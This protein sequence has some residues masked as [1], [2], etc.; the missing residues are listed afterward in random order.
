MCEDIARRVR[1][2]TRRVLRLASVRAALVLSLL[3]PLTASE[4][5]AAITFV[6]NIGANAS[7]TTGTSIAVM[8]PSAIPVGNEVVLTVAF[9]ATSGTVSVSDT[10]HGTYAVAA[11]VTNASNVRTVILAVRVTSAYS[12]GQTITVATPTA[13]RR[14]LSAN[15]FSG[16]S[17]TPVDRTA[18]ATGNSISP[19]SGATL[20]TTQ[21][22]E[23][24][25]GAIGVNG[26]ATDTF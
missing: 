26:Q 1:M 15:E 24:L 14:A 17:T 25:L 12:A 13:L 23:L 16:L 2:K 18:T 8:V 11:D 20:A 21:N 3:L 6:K 22:S 7:A 5:T 9:T 10:S 19:S 4:A